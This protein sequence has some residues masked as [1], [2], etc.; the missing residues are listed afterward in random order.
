M[1]LKRGF[2]EKKGK[3]KKKKKKSVKICDWEIVHNEVQNIS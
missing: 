1:S 2:K 3:R